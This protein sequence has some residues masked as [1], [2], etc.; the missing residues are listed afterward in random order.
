SYTFRYPRRSPRLL[1]KHQP[2]LKALAI[3]KNQIHILGTPAFSLSATS[4]YID[5]EGDPDRDFYY[6]I[7]LR[8]ASEN[9]AVRCS[10]WADTQEDERV[11]WANCLR[12][13]SEL[14]SPCLIHYGAYETQFLKRMI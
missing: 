4:V 9:P 5:V 7:G 3:R 11:I 6:L 2:A 10:Y 13:L 1:P 8:I 12:T 14:T